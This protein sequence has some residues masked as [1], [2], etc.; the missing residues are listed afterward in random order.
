MIQIEESITQMAK[1]TDLSKV[2]LEQ[3]AA[4]DKELKTLRAANKNYLKTM[5]LSQIAKAYTAELNR[6]VVE[7]I[8]IMQQKINSEMMN[9]NNTAHLTL[10]RFL[11]ELGHD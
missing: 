5:E 4:I 9:I 2:V 10:N 7:Q 8:A 1:T 3:Y 11:L 6:L